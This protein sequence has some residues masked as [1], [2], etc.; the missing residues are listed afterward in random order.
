MRTARLPVRVLA[1]GA[2]AAGLV[3][4]SVIGADAA[5]AGHDI[6]LTKLA[7]YDSG[8]GEAGAEIVAYDAG[9]ARMFITVGELNALDI[10][11]L[12]D[13]S[14]PA[15]LSRVDLSPHGEGINS[16]AARDGVVLVAVEGADGA[17]GSVVV[18]DVDGSFVTSYEA[19]YLPDMV[20]ISAT[21]R[22][23]VAANEGE[24]VCDGDELLVDPPGSITVIDLLRK[25]AR[26]ADFS[27]F[28]GN[29]EFL[30]ADDVRI[31]FP[32]SDAAQDLEPEYVAINHNSRLAYVSL[33][34]N[35]A[36][37]IVDLRTARVIGIEG[38]GY[39]DHGVAGN[40]LD[41]SNRDGGEAI[42]T[43]NVLGMYQPDAIDEAKIGGESYLFTANEGDARDYDCF[44]EETRVKDLGDDFGL[45]VDVPPYAESDL[46]DE[47][48]G[49]LKTTGA[50]PTDADGDGGV[51]QVYAYGARSFSIWDAAGDLVWDSGDDFEQI[52]AGTPYFNLDEDEVDGRSDD[53]GPEPEAIVVGRFQGSHYAFIGLERSGGVMVYDVSIP[54]EPRFVTYLNTGDDISPEG[55]T[56]VRNVDSPTGNP[57]LLAAH[58]VSGT[59]AVYEIT[60]ATGR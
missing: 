53:K 26:E 29:E 40:G 46:E 35:N 34:E 55:F 15:L 42:D 50:Y 44:S 1:G 11:D 54:T 39:K 14:A 3:A 10:V 41:P 36:L 60:Q 7:A 17:R 16:V 4:S 49:R 13:P 22:Y 59:T 19:G 45:T 2:L 25:T 56:Y 47:A 31:F 58:E 52:L 33:Q 23:A 24:P 28:I 32:G 6:D 20:T 8:V 9:S 48:L 37:A 51:E 38:L 12:S 21:G 27:S 57:L 5:K 18:L 43:W 30:R